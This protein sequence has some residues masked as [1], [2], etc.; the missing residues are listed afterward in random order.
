MKASIVL[1]GNAELVFGHG[2]LQFERVL[3]TVATSSRLAIATYS[4]PTLLSD[5]LI[6]TIPHG[7]LIE[8]VTAL[9]AYD[10]KI[11]WFMQMLQTFVTLNANVLVPYKGEISIFFNERNHS[12]MLLT[13]TAA[14]IGSANFSHGSKHHFEGGICV[15]DRDVCSR[16]YL[17]FFCPLVNASKRF[18]GVDRAVEVQ[19][20]HLGE[21]ASELIDA[22]QSEFESADW[23]NLQRLYDSIRN[24]GKT[25]VVSSKVDDLISNWTPP[26][27]Q[28]IGAII[29]DLR[30]IESDFGTCEW[31]SD[32]NGERGFQQAFSE[33]LE[34]S[35][36]NDLDSFSESANEAVED[37]VERQDAVSQCMVK[38][39]SPLLE[40]QLE[41]E[42]L[43][44]C[45][46]QRFENEDV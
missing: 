19:L 12:K 29:D 36:E 24:L 4:L 15:F 45:V 20:W 2:F 44:K 37:I 22:A 27:I 26:R 13:D 9:P 30:Q 18:V 5:R 38:L 11:D 33:L 16:I 46:E 17:D 34:S 6:R 21:I 41:L 35:P 40:L 31:Q 25:C 23:R 42:A 8:L 14:Y 1:G 43:A 32:F 3:E 28:E 39:K 10:P 7:C